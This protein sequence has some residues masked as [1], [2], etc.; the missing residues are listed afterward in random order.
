M[1]ISQR[2]LCRAVEVY[3]WSVHCFIVCTS[4][5]NEKKK[6]KVMILWANSLLLKKWANRA[7]W[8]SISNI[9][10]S[11]GGIMLLCPACGP[12][13]SQSLIPPPQDLKGLSLQIAPL[14]CWDSMKDGCHCAV[15]V[16]APIWC[17]AIKGLLGAERPDGFVMR[18]VA[19][20]NGFPLPLPLLPSA[21][22]PRHSRL[23]ACHSMY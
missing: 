5:F 4:V 6:K 8:W 18:T 1:A 7:K 12:V 14:C 17:A 20:Q 16:T 23:P 11:T 13:P 3:F 19:S 15:R 9:P 21:A 22:G 10:Q 2:H